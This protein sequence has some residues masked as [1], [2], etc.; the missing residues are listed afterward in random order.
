MSAQQSNDPVQQPQA[1]Q[2]YQGP[3]QTRL[4]TEA[5]V[6]HQHV[7]RLFNLHHGIA[8]RRQS[9]AL[10]WMWERIDAG[11]KLAFRQHPQV[12]PQLD[13]LTRQVA[14]GGVA[15]ST[16]ARQLLSL[17]AERGHSQGTG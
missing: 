13:A 7:A 5:F 9:Q 10:A 14:S 16:A 3:P 1:G 17:Y 4:V 2:R 6:S 8:T 11:L 12:R 15:A